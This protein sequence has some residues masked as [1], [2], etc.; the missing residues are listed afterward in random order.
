MVDWFDVVELVVMDDV[1]MR[2]SRW[3]MGSEKHCVACVTDEISEKNWRW[4][5]D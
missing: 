3:R 4:V 5:Y 1:G 2:G